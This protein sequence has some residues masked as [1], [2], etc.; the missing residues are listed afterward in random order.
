MIVRTAR[1]TRVNR[2]RGLDCSYEIE[3]S[4]SAANG[5]TCFAAKWCDLAFELDG[6]L[7]HF[8]ECG[9]GLGVCLESSLRDDEL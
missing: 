3:M 9:D 4:H 8:V 2:K 1:C 7:H 5:K 6:V